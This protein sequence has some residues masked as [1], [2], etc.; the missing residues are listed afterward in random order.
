MNPIGP[1]VPDLRPTPFSISWWFRCPMDFSGKNRLTYFER[2]WRSWEML[3][4]FNFSI[5]NHSRNE[6]DSKTWQLNRMAFL[7]NS[8]RFCYVVMFHDQQCMLQRISGPLLLILGDDFHPMVKPYQPYTQEHLRD[9]INPQPPQKHRPYWRE[10]M[11]EFFFHID[12]FDIKK[13]GFWNQTCHL[14]KNLLIRRLAPRND[15][16][17]DQQ[18]PPLHPQKSA[19]PVT[20]HQMGDQKTGPDH[21]V[22]WSL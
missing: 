14:K 13:D 15:S 20:S 12:D 6:S 7:L 11:E 10:F 4:C 1:E 3:A 22:P 16:W 17:F 5:S 18:K 2:S 19:S 9:K 21:R 8:G